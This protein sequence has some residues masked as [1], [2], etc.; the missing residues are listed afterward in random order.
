MRDDKHLSL[1]TEERLPWLEPVEP[2]IVQKSQS[3]G[4]IWALGIAVAGAVSLV[5]GGLWWMSNR[6]VSLNGDGSVIAAPPLPYKVRPD[7][8]GGM[9]VEGQGDA[10]FAAS[11]GADANGQLDLAAESETPVQA[12]RVAPAKSAAPVAMGQKASATVSVGGV[13]VPARPNIAG[14]RPAPGQPSDATGTGLIQLGTYSDAAS[15]NQAYRALTQRYAVLDGLPR[16]TAKT[17]VA[18][19]TF[20]QL[21]ISAG[22]Q[23]QNVCA[24]LKAGGASCS[25][26]K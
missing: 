7:D 12:Q 6:E 18:G 8:I 22:A 5:F 16:Q 1:D 14:P 21:R 15:A 24:R 9:T 23:A 25:L 11:E 2:V 26:V 10:A 13:L 3:S 19:K 4:K 20:Y 17:I